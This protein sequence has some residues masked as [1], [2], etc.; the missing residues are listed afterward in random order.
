MT[1]V[2][3]WVPRVLSMV[4]GITLLFLVIQYLLGL[5]TNVYAP[6]TF[7]PNTSYPSLDWHYMIGDT[8]FVLSLLTLIFAVLTKEARAIVPAVVLVVAVYVAGQFG[9]DYVGSTPN[10]PLDSFGMRVMFLIAFVSAVALAGLS[11]RITKGTAVQP[12]SVTPGATT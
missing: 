5:W 2:R 6:S 9:M 12:P 1:P 8:V 7:T 3:P 4:T 10:N 11:R